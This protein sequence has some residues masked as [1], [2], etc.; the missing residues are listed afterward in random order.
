M[1]LKVKKMLQEKEKGGKK[2][3]QQTDKLPSFT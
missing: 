3:K 2:K 1:E